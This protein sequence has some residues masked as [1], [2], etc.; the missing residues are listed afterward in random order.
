MSSTLCITRPP[1]ALHPV[2]HCIPHNATFQIIS[3]IGHIIAPHHILHR[4]SQ[5]APHVLHNCIIPS[6]QSVITPNSTSHCHVSHNI[7][8][9]ISIPPHSTSHHLPHHALITPPTLPRIVSCRV[10]AHT[11]PRSTSHNVPHSSPHTTSFHI[12]QRSTFH[13][14]DH[15]LPRSTSHNVPHSMPQ[16]ILYRLVPHHTTFHI[17]CHSP[18]STDSFHI[19]QRSTFHATA[20]TLRRRSTSYSMPQP[21]HQSILHHRF[22]RLELTVCAYNLLYHISNPT[23]K[24]WWKIKIKLYQV[25]HQYDIQSIT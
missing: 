8:Y 20:H 22:E 9:H 5:A 13:A 12:A 25:I 19:T 14:T 21:T 7:P 4:I 16:P 15:T 6:H 2:S 18:Y 3:Y 11:L 10:T 24:W 23:Q 1:L 17:P